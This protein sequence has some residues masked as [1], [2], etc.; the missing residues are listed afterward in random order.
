L[1]CSGS[2][3]GYRIPSIN[4][5]H[6]TPVQFLAANHLVGGGDDASI[7]AKDGWIVSGDGLGGSQVAMLACGV[8]HREVGAVVKNICAVFSQHS[9]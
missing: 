3:T 5:A 9:N 6:I 4:Y 7:K 8:N 2:Y 1:I